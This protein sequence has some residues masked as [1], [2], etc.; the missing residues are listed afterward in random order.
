[1]F[2]TKRVEPYVVDFVSMADHRISSLNNEVTKLK[3][4]LFLSNEHIETLKSQVRLIYMF[5]HLG[6]LQVYN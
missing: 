2:S 4:E 1:M 6:M 5:F 3:E